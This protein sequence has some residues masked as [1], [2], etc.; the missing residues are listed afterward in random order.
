MNR[1]R[2]WCLEH[3]S[4]VF[5]TFYLLLKLLEILNLGKFWYNDNCENTV[6]LR[7]KIPL[8]S[9]HRRGDEGLMMIMRKRMIMKE[10][11]KCLKDYYFNFFISLG[12]YHAW[13]NVA[14]LNFNK[15]VLFFLYGISA[16]L[17]DSLTPRWW[18]GSLF[19]ASSCYRHISLQ[20]HHRLV[21]SHEEAVTPNPW[22]TAIQ[23]E[24]LK[25]H[26]IINNLYV[27]LLK[28][29]LL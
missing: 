11:L 25:G 28:P 12:N 6:F 21:W 3:F 23:K 1:K 14:K 5:F 17:L 4:F 29:T 2:Q 10:F 22:K 13:I 9:S 7:I 18:G 24:T 26:R 15:A 19:L 20:S 8:N 27:L 16:L